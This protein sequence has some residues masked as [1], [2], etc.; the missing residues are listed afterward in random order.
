MRKL[1]MAMAAILILSG[2]VLAQA[3]GDPAKGVSATGTVRK[4]DAEKRIVNL[5]H[6]P[7][8]AV[9]WPAMT[10]DFAVAPGV[11]LTGVRPG[12]TVDFTLAPGPGKDYVIMQVKPKS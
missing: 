9:R 10:M 3:P 6:G 1:S 11:D 4:V 5:S 12:Q 2:P 8:P 7:I